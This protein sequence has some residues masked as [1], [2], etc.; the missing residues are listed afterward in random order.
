[1]TI[2]RDIAAPL[3]RVWAAWSN[4]DTLQKWWGPEGFSCR[5]ER[6]DLRAGG[7]WVFDMVGPDGTV[8]PNHHKY[9]RFGPETGIEYS[10]HWGEDGPKHADASVRFKEMSGST[11]V[12]LQMI[13]A[14]VDDF[15]G[16]TA[17]GAERL[18][19]QTLAK[20]EKAIDAEG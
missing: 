7:E 3:A 9:H 19:Q 4:P 1:M 6:I 2:Q 15:E 17:A 5:T 11:S 18:G 12:T 14:T 10:L 8:Y 20:L 13:F 16:A